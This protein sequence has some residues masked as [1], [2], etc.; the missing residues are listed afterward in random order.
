MVRARLVDLDT[1]DSWISGHG[2]THQDIDLVIDAGHVGSYDPKL[3]ELV[4]QTA[5]EKHLHPIKPWR[6]ICLAGAAAPLDM[7]GLPPGLSIVPRRD[8]A[9]WRTVA[10]HNP[11][12]M[13]Y[14]DYGISHPDLTEPPPLA[15]TRAT[16]S[17]RYTT[18][19]DWIVL[20][21]KPMAGAKGQ[22]MPILY[23]AHAKKLAGDPR[24]NGLSNRCWG[25][26]RI[27]QISSSGSGPAGNRTSWVAIGVNRHLSL[28]AARLP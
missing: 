4:V 27:E 8:W 12:N 11:F 24:F 3:F 6:S 13:H 2:W 16:V 18:E 22:P 19:D 28:V 15:M 26:T 25:D 20:K 23:R 5:I 17:V 9:L 1:L 7:T 21:G 10:T 14:G